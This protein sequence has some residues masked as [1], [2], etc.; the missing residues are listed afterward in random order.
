M[1]PWC[2][3]CWLVC[4]G[5]SRDHTEPGQKLKKFTLNTFWCHGCS[6]RK[7]NALFCVV[8]NHSANAQVVPLIAF[9]WRIGLQQELMCSSAGRTNIH[10]TLQ[11]PLDGILNTPLVSFPLSIVRAVFSLVYS[12]FVLCSRPSPQWED[13]FSSK[14]SRGIQLPLYQDLFS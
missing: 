14:D 8:V 12:L 4:Q 9:M 6:Y 13:C 10:C 1:F 7:C 11:M 2:A 5:A 3:C